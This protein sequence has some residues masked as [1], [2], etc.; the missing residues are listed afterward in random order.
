MLVLVAGTIGYFNYQLTSIERFEVPVDEAESNEPRN[1]LLVGSD[2]RTALDPDDPANDR[3]LGDEQS[4]TEGSRTDTIMILRVDPAVGRAALLSVPR[5][6]FVPIADTGNRNR[7]NVAYARGREVLIDT[8]RED[9]DIPIHHYVEVDFVGFQKLVDAIGGV[10]LYFDEPVRDTGSGLVVETTGCVS[11]DGD[12]ALAFAR[13]RHLEIENPSTGRWRPDESADSGRIRRQQHLLRRA[14]GKAVDTGLEDPGAIDDLVSVAVD[15]VGLDPTLA[16]GEVYALAQ[17]FG[18]F[19][20]ETLDTYTIPGV[21]IR[22]SGGA[23]VLDMVERDAEP[24][25]NIFRGLPPETLTPPDGQRRRAQRDGN[26]GSGPR[27]LR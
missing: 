11:L 22:T 18:S 23:S 7:I 2:S 9:F 8:I 15:H 5:D 20:A 25:L 16:L 21:S 17:R 3:F 12:Q 10:S 13:A 24:I 14:I 4:G 19:D 1:Y 27:R 6:L 26:R